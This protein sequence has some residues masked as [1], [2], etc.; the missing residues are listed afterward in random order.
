[1]DNFILSTKLVVLARQMLQKHHYF[2]FANSIEGSVFGE[3]GRIL[4]NFCRGKKKPQ[5]KQQKKINNWDGLSCNKLV[6]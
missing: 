3:N 5:K 2:V 6:G 1:M 4:T